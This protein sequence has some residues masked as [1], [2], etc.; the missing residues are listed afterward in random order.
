MLADE[1]TVQQL[2]PHNDRMLLML[3]WFRLHTR[4]S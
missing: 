2:K 1:K 4:R 3:M